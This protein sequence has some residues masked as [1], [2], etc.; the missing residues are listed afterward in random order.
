MSVIAWAHRGGA[1]LPANVGIENTLRAFRNAVDLGYSH[2]E[3][4][5]HASRDGVLYAFHDTNLL[6]MTGRSARISEL[7]SADIDSLRVGGR[8]P[9]LRI[10]ELIEA[11]PGCRFSIDVKSDDAVDLAIEEFRRL[12]V[13]DR[14]IVG[15][16]DHRRTLRLRAGLPRAVSALSRREMAWLVSGGPVPRRTV[17]AAPVTW[18]GVPIITPRLVARAKRRGIPVFAWTIDDA[19]EM[20]RLLDLGVDGIMADQIDELRDLLLARGQWPSPPPRVLP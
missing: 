17:A 9:L 4:D 18:G 10:A 2:L 6:R 7:A 16:F 20:A 11:F 1:L 3:T 13:D 19:D 8:E 14:L 12:A 5:V 15:S